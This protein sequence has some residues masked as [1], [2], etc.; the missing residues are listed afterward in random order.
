M[1]PDVIRTVNLT[2]WLQTCQ[3]FRLEMTLKIN[4]YSL[5]A[6]RG[7]ESGSKLIFPLDGA[8][9]SGFK[10]FSTAFLG[11]SEGKMKQCYLFSEARYGLFHAWMVK[12]RL[13]SE[14]QCEPWETTVPQRRLAAKLAKVLAFKH[15]NV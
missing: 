11:G 5:K 15:G 9:I 8:K 13:P 4:G 6:K 3:E 12:E 14:S 2:A 10:I 1:I 7:T